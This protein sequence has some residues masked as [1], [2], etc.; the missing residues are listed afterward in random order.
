MSAPST[1]FFE[2]NFA[3]N[4]ELVGLARGLPMPEVLNRGF[5]NDPFKFLNMVD[6]MNKIYNSTRFQPDPIFQRYSVGDRGKRQVITNVTSSGGNLTLTFTDPNYV[7]FV[8]DDTVATSPVSPFVG[9]VIAAQPGQITIKNYTNN[10]NFASAYTVNRE[11]IQ[12][13]RALGISDD[14]ISLQPNI[15]PDSDF[16]WPS[17][18]DH[19]AKWSYNDTRSMMDIKWMSEGAS[20]LFSAPIMGN[21]LEELQWKRMAAM[22]FGIGVPFDVNSNESQSLGIIPSIDQRGGYFKNDG[23][24]VVKQDFLDGFAQIRRNGG[25]NDVV[26]AMG[27]KHREKFNEFFREDIRYDGTINMK[28]AQSDAPFVVDK[29]QLP[30][31]EQVKVMNLEYFNS[32]RS[33]TAAS[34]TLPGARGME[35]ATLILDMSPVPTFGGGSVAN[36]QKCVFENNGKGVEYSFAFNKGLS[37]INIPSVTSSQESSFIN[38]A[39]EFG[40]GMKASDQ[41]RIYTNCC[42]YLQAPERAAFLKG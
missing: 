37:P 24:P 22:F 9:K 27:Y 1:K 6:F 3:Q 8:V 33:G 23:T 15:L 38:L 4:W 35:D 41:F 11:V 2:Q 21:A 16:N 39:T 32:P 31:G 25:F 19:V 13:T 26:M 7:G 40:H 5:D 17:F 20:P 12:I 18:I 10:P 14:N 34:A 29:F 30:S 42:Y 36:I 28:V